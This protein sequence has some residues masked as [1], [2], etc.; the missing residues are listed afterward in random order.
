MLANHW[1][2]TSALRQELEKQAAALQGWESQAKLHEQK[3]SDLESELESARY[4]L[5]RLEK[6][7]EALE[8]WELQARMHEASSQDLQA[9]LGH[10]LETLASTEMALSNRDEELRR[11]QQRANE[12]QQEKADIQLKLSATLERLRG[13]EADLLELNARM[14]ELCERQ[15]EANAISQAHNAELQRKLESALAA[16]TEELVAKR[17]LEDELSA[18][19]EELA[20]KT[21]EL[22][23]CAGE[24]E[25]RTVDRNR[26]V[27]ELRGRLEATLEKLAE[28]E[29]ELLA[30]T[31]R[32]QHV[33][34][35]AALSW[36]PAMSRSCRSPGSLSLCS[37]LSTNASPT[38]AEGSAGVCGLESV[39][40]T[41]TNGIADAPKADK[42]LNA[43]PWQVVE[44]R[45][46]NQSM[47]EANNVTF[48]LEAVIRQ[49]NADLKE[50]QEQLADSH[51][52]VASLTQE[53]ASSKE[54]L[55]TTI[56]KLSLLRQEH[57]RLA[58][59]LQEARQ[60]KD[61]A[62]AAQHAAQEAFRK[63]DQLWKEFAALE[64]RLENETMEKERERG[65]V[66]QLIDQMT[67]IRSV[68]A[69]V[70]TT[71][72]EDLAACAAQRELVRSEL[73]AL[74]LLTDEAQRSHGEVVSSLHRISMHQQQNRIANETHGV[75][76]ILGKEHANEKMLSDAL[77]MQTL[78][79]EPARR[80]KENVHILHIQQLQAAAHNAQTQLLV[81]REA[82]ASQSKEMEREKRLLANAHVTLQ[83]QQDAAEARI[84]STIT[85]RVH[86][87]VKEAEARMAE[88]AH[89]LRCGFLR[90]GWAGPFVC[91]RARTA[92]VCARL[93]MQAYAWIHLHDFCSH[94]LMHA[95]AGRVL[96]RPNPS[97]VLCKFAWQHV[98]E[99]HGAMRWR[100]LGN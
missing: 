20:A 87:A 64:I 98:L 14:Q 89:S 99:K 27:A 11:W 44:A 66:S 25:Q 51:G 43:T 75:T 81:M 33:V 83:R 9:R 6:R 7:A 31:A 40:N 60:Q 94:A 74:R 80:E 12:E 59:M 58:Q 47:E 55:E 70:G 77:L 4:T 50:T 39:A 42:R 86:A 22:L 41:T 45:L 57:E 52:Q 84:E 85:A 65:K 73:Q 88:N 21:N 72:Y 3:N 29:A 78:A 95:R 1:L 71:F 93:L 35:E 19:T 10:A 5:S 67:G 54:Q 79:L 24:Q 56:C 34:R 100:K 17:N 90:Q 63:K 30:A 18:R 76:A 49:S 16:E 53:L 38:R 36:S 13:K 8:G 92:C 46:V 23:E 37:D 26:E 97:L 15:Q 62:E 61:V 32:S 82:L 2:H 69:E 48:E 68:V 96:R 91:E 28:K